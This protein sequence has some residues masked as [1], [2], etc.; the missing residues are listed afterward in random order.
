MHHTQRSIFFVGLLISG[1][2]TSLLVQSGTAAPPRASKDPTALA[3]YDPN[4]GKD[5]TIY[6]IPVDGT[7]DLGLAPFVERIV[8]HAKPKDV[9]ILR[10]KTFGGRIDAAVR[11]RDALL[12]SPAPTVAYIDQRAISAGALISL[13]CDTIIMSD[14]ASIGA[15]TPVQQGAN[16]EMQPTSEKVVSY[17]RA[18][19]RA[20]AEAN[21]RRGDIAEAMVDPDMAIAG[22]NDKGKLLTLTSERAI[23]LGI[24]DAIATDFDA[25]IVLLNLNQATRVTP[26]TDWGEK[27][28]RFLTDPTVSSLLMTLGFLGLLI[29]LYT[30]GFGAT[31]LI[32]VLCLILFFF[33]QYT[34]HL[35]GMEE[36]LLF[37]VGAILLGIE[38][39]ILPGFGIAGVTGIAAIAASMIMAMIELRLPMDV[40]FEL[41]YAQEAI[42]SAAG[43]ILL[44]IGVVICAGVLLTRYLPRSRLG[45]WMILQSAVGKSSGEADAAAT[46]P[47]ENQSPTLHIGLQGRAITPLRPAGMMIIGTHRIDVVTDGP[48]VERDVLVEITEIHGSRV[49]V[50][51]VSPQEVSP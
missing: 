44:S 4:G 46:S 42:T 19:M 37:A 11:I 9:L 28:A 13:A 26:T 43:R 14:G 15:A 29:E 7:I 25:A 30:P 41:G 3:G 47:S 17:M 21:Q 38:V 12:A 48:F 18:E 51:A 8:H 40:S 33:G 27:I 2:A 16:G 39:F 32:G 20:T 49:V 22:I 6:E 10:I 35:A 31:G 24:A 50:R 45:R 1:L 23:T 36:V 34:A 5:K